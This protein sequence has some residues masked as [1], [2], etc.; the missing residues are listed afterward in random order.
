MSY[1]PPFTITSEILNPKADISQEANS[2]PF[3]H[4]MLSVITRTLAQN[5]P[6]NAPVNASVKID[7]LKTPEAILRL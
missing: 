5:A 4:F 1:K 3:I 2:T 6:V 7:G